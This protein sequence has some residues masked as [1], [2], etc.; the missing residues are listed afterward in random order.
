MGFTLVLVIIIN[1]MNPKLHISKSFALNF[2]IQVET[3]KNLI[4][5]SNFVCLSF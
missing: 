4:L 2:K 5:I 3:Q 1:T